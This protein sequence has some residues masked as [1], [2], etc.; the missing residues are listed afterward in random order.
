MKSVLIGCFSFLLFISTTVSALEI[1][2]KAPFLTQLED[3]QNPEFVSTPEPDHQALI[4]AFDQAQK[5]IYVGIFG[6]SNLKI[7]NSLSAAHQRG[8]HVV[9]L[10]DKYCS[11]NPK[12]LEIYNKLKADGVEIY[13]T[14]AGFSISHWKM[15]VIDE[16]KAFI[17]SMN[18]IIRT[19]QMRDVGLFFTNPNL[20]KEMI[21]VFNSDIENAKNQTTTTPPLT[22][23]NLVWSPNNSEEKLSQLILAAQKTVE[24]WI[25]NMGSQTIHTALKTAVSRGVKVRVLTSMCS[26]GMPAPAAFKN[27]KDLVSG[28]VIVQVMPFPATK[29]VP[30]IH[31]KTITIDRETVFLGSENFSAHSLLKSRELGIIFKNSEIETKM[32]QLFEKDWAQSVALPAEA[33]ATC[34]PLSVAI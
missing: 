27:L 4:N 14:S 12:R 28:N 18:F 23:A 16:V 13:T 25:E 24:I 20:V 1:Q 34:S 9:V 31:A 22:A 2:P 30:Y 17:S 26:M 3:L 29:D 15:F 19:E 33:P 21:S 32:N 7:A 8:V 10:C 11:N 5:S 6:I